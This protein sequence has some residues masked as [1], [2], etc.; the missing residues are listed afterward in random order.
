MKGIICM[1]RICLTTGAQH[2]DYYDGF[3]IRPTSA[4]PP[5]VHHQLVILFHLFVVSSASITNS[6]PYTHL[7]IL[8]KCCCRRNGFSEYLTCAS[9]LF[10]LST[11]NSHYFETGSARR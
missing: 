7:V 4:L 2:R 6:F 3:H 9:H 1:I 10:Y 5:P 11:I 8:S